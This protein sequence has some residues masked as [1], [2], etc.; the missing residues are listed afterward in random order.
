MLQQTMS[1]ENLAKIFKRLRKLT[2]NPKKCRFGLSKVTFVGHD[3]D[4]EGV[5]F[6][7]Q[8]K[9]KVSDCPRPINSKGLRSFSGLANYFIDHIKNHSVKV[10]ILQ[11]NALQRK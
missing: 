3:I 10:V 2:S 11:K 1:S 8:Q 9:Q 7:R 6:S 5:L 4:H